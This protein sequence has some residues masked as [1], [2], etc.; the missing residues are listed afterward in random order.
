VKLSR[1]AAASPIGSKSYVFTREEARLRLTYPQEPEF[2]GG[3]LP[4]ANIGVLA[5]ILVIEDGVRDVSLW[6]T[7]FDVLLWTGTWH[8]LSYMQ[9]LPFKKVLCPIDFSQP[10]HK[11][12]DAARKLVVH[13]AGELWIVHVVEPV[14]PLYPTTPESSLSF[15]VAGY[16]KELQI[17][18]EKTL[19]DLI[20][21]KG[22]VAE[23]SK[24]HPVVTRGAA[25]SEITRIAEEED[26]DLLVIATHG[27]TGWRHL[28]FGSVAEK[29]V[30]LAPCPVLTIQAL[31]SEDRRP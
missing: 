9:M 11:A 23:I 25:A 27:R 1:Q 2:K 24:V 5:H 3:T 4:A 14:P 16:E 28:V 10:S 17:F 22:I 21:E 6:N 29:V 20:K 13:F 8:I 26:I 18:S 15:D 30:R 7:G 31:P 19:R 12:L